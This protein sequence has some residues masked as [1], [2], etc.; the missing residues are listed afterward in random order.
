MFAMRGYQV[1]LLPLVCLA[2]AGLLLST[3]DAKPTNPCHNGKYSL[4]VLAKAPLAQEVP[5]L[6]KAA[7]P[8]P[9]ARVHQVKH[10]A[11]QERRAHRV[12]HHRLLWRLRR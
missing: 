6:E 10:T 9:V 11:A 3:A 4:L 1:L 12:R 7:A 5:A 8:K 2:L